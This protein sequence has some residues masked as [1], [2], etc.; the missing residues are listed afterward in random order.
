[1][2]V[3]NFE[4]KEYQDPACT[5]IFSTPILPL[6]GSDS[7][8]IHFLLSLFIRTKGA[9]KDLAVNFLRLDTLRGT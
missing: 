8:I 9:A 2:P 4:R 6:S 7:K 3:A 1:M 5:F